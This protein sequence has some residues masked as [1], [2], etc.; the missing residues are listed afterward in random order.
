MKKL[1]PRL[2]AA[3]TTVSVLM[4]AGGATKSGW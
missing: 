4:S 3:L 2:Y 1:S